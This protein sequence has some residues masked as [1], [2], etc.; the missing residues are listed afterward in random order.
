MTALA[1][2]RGDA[3]RWIASAVVV[4]GLHALGAA[5]LLTWHDPVG[6]GEDSSAIVVDLA[7][8][9]PPSDSAEDLAPGP[10]QQEAP[11]P[12]P[13]Q[14]AEP[15]VEPKPDDT[16]EAKIEAKPEEKPQEKVEAPPAPVPPVAAVP[17]P[18]T[19][20]P[21][22]PPEPQV[23]P[24]PPSNIPPAP[25]TTAPPR[26]HTASAAAINAW[27]KA[28]VAQ[29]QRHKTYPPAARAHGEKGVVRV[30]FSID[31]RG[32][33]VAK[34][35]AKA[36]GHVTLDEAAIETLQQAQFPPAP[37]DLPGEAFNFTVPSAVSIR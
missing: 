14:K 19:I 8:Y 15:T 28:I 4:V 26:P 5:T 33:L 21:P 6:W 12:A 34:S 22:P 27:H 18:D 24:A 25:A 1:A 7:P 2:A 11:A 37:A 35:I 29:I 17:P 32:R 30:A 3:T 31:R 9:A 10:I 13:E 16:V 23:Q 36:S 20:A